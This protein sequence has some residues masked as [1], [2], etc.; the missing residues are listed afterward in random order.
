MRS[1]KPSDSEAEEAVKLLIRWIGDDPNREGLVD[2][3]KRVLNVY[4]D[5]FSGY[6]V[7]ALSIRDS[8]LLNEGYNDMVILKDTKFTSYCEHHIVPMKG[9]ISIAYVPDKLILGIG[10]IIK[11]INYFTKRL[12]LQE[13]LTMEI[14]KALND[15]LLPKGTIVT[16][17]AVH[18]C[19]ACYEEKDKNDLKLQTIYAIGIFQ[20]NIELRREFFANI[21]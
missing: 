14:A 17:E 8:V 9:K 21:G 15:Y 12:Q 1:N 19:V 5:L 10:K 11:L 4:K 7:D 13:R 18:D 16:I 6:E 20:D 3:A 2:T